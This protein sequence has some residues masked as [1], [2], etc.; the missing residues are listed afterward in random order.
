MTVVSLCGPVSTAHCT[1]ER[2]SRFSP[3]EV[4]APRYDEFMAASDALADRP[5]DLRDVLTFGSGHMVTARSGP[6]Q[7]AVDLS[8]APGSVV[9]QM[10]GAAEMFELAVSVRHHLYLGWRD[11]IQGFWR[12]A[13]RAPHYHPSPCAHRQRIPLFGAL[14]RDLRLVTSNA[15]L[16]SGLVKSEYHVRL[17]TQAPLFFLF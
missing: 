9:E 1:T 14:T 13:R 16:S 3:A 17:T 4:R 2:R 7:Q 5:Q 11:T 15:A 6:E 12:G 10:A 8:A